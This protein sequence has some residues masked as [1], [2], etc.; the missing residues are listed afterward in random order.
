MARFPILHIMRMAAIFSLGA[1]TALAATEA[2]ARFAFPENKE[3]SCQT[4]ENMSHV[5]PNCVSAM[6]IAEGREFI[7]RYNECGYRTAESCGTKTPG[8]I[9][10]AVLGTS[11]GSGY[12]VD[13]DD[14][15]TAQASTELSRLCARPVEFQ[16]V[17]IYWP[18][19]P[20]G[21]EWDEIDTRIDEAL[22]L[23]PDMA[24]LLVSTWDLYTYGDPATSIAPVSAWKASQ[25]YKVLHATAYFFRNAAEQSRAV[26]ALR[27]FMYR[28]EATFLQLYLQHGDE[29]D[30]LRSPLSEAWHTR[31]SLLD[32]V[33][34]RL[35]ARARQQKVPVAVLFSPGAA[36][37]LLARNPDQTVGLDAD[38]IGREAQAIAARNGARYI[39][40]TPAISHAARPS[41]LYFMVN[42][43]P[44]Q[45]GHSFIAKELLTGL[46]KS[47][48]FEACRH[49]RLVSD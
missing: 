40:P 19:L 6:Q 18:R 37:V 29:A 41:E 39:D 27:H 21:S 33:L 10:V 16:N 25:A 11:I 42:G 20:A 38:A 9:R 3:N 32:K 2:I 35:A 31:L 14:M 46:L 48:A 28:D 4:S 49:Q 5:K 24:V 23:R 47:E 34:S 15:F 8:T 17:S 45:R 1:I 12:G 26:L 22:R 44:N 13:Y 36:Q 7:N 43:H 30:F